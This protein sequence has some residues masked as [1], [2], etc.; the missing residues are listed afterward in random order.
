[1]GGDRSLVI[2]ADHP[3]IAGHFPGNPVVPG[4][5]ILTEILTAIVE[6][7]PYAGVVTGVPRVKF[8]SFLRPGEPFDL[9]WEEISGDEISESVIAFTC[10]AGR[11]PVASGRLTVGR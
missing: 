7:L 1:M 6:A 9:H 5:V 8:P 10:T 3:A 4:V 11:R 2:D